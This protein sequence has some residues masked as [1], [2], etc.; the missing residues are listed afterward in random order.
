MIITRA[1]RTEIYPTAEQV[2]AFRKTCA[3][4][5]FVYNWALCRKIEAYRDEEANP[6]LVTQWKKELQGIKK[7]LK[8]IIEV[9][10]GFVDKKTGE[11]VASERVAELRSLLQH[12]EQELQKY[13]PK[14]LR[15]ADLQGIELTK[16]KEKEPWLKEVPGQ[17]LLASLQNNDRAFDRFTDKIKREGA[18]PRK[19]KIMRQPG[20]LYRWYGEEMV[21][22]GQIE[23]PNLEY[24]PRF[25][26]ARDGLGGFKFFSLIRIKRRE[27]KVRGIEGFIRLAETD[28]IPLPERDAAWVDGSNNNAGMWKKDGSFEYV[29]WTRPD[30]S[31]GLLPVGQRRFASGAITEDRGRWY[32][33]I[34][35][36][37][38]VP[39]P[40]PPDGV[41]VFAVHLGLNRLATFS[42]GTFIARPPHYEQMEKR[43]ARLNRSLARG[44]E[45]GKKVGRRSK[46]TND[47][48]ERR[49]EKG[50]LEAHIANQRKAFSHELTQR[51]TAR[52]PKIL[53]LHEWGIQGMMRDDGKRVVKKKKSNGE[54][55]EY[56]YRV[57]LAKPISHAAWGM[58]NI[59]I[60]YKSLWQGTTIVVAPSDFPV[61][62]RCSSCGELNPDMAV[63]NPPAMF[64]CKCGNKL[65]REDNSTKNLW[66]YGHQYLA[67]ME[68]TP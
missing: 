1:Y 51:I 18:R 21:N 46:Q 25:Q 56:T 64:K 63:P 36:T 13:K 42:D 3:A 23:Y 16:L 29:N 26:T 49:K 9:D 11:I 14:F 31:A 39:D 24:Y 7:S 33:A 12:A 8:G 22:S 32:V 20:F 53:V 61:T 10:G 2:I 30:K 65:H 15:Q 34:T 38:S 6:E 54:E 50:E 45:V 5:R 35:F 60:K 58:L 28:A 48:R 4:V 19:K 68:A 17:A 59:Q 27:I 44:R 57:N 41:D 37:E 40:L 66:W 62:Q 52:R 55:V 47:Y 43:L 67:Q